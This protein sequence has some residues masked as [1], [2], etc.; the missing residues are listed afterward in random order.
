M[1]VLSLMLGVARQASANQ[2]GTS[3]NDRTTNMI[4]L[5]QLGGGGADVITSRYTDGLRAATV[6]CKGGAYDGLVCSFFIDLTICTWPGEGV[7]APGKIGWQHEITADP[8]TAD[9]GNS[10]T[11]QVTVDSGVA[12]Q[13]IEQATAAPESVEPTSTPEPTA[14]A[15]ATATVEPTADDGSATDT[16]EL[17]KTDVTVEPAE[18]P[19][20][21][22]DTQPDVVNVL[23]AGPFI[24]VTFEAAP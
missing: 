18:T 4:T 19:V 17:P 24:E 9:P 13:N 10:S 1:L 23:D 3:V 16:G 12:T 22:P 11:T 6:T 2:S 21:E 14:P 5:C 20:V 15:E 8:A 7:G